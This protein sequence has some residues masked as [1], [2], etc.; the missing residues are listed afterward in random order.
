MV[1]DVFLGDPMLDRVMGVVM[2]LAR[3]LYVANDRVRALE[4]LL[5]QR[6][7]LDP[8]A[9]DRYEPTP[10]LAERWRLA[11]DEYVERLLRQIIQPEADE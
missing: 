2:S 10:E 3:E 1:K 6:G 4:Q 9:I 7:F 5:M 11:R 8:E